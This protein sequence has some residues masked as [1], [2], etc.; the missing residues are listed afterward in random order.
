[1]P[2]VHVSAMGVSSLLEPV[3]LDDSFVLARGQLFFEVDTREMK[4]GDG[5]TA[6]SSLDPVGGGSDPGGSTS[7]GAAVPTTG[8]WAKGDV[9]WNTLPAAGENVGWVCLVAGTP[10]TWAAFGPINV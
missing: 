10:G 7:S 3:Y 4:I 2:N 6:W 1:M 8:T 9:F 5:V